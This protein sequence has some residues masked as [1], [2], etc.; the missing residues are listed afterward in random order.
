MLRL[1]L[2]GYGFSSYIRGQLVLQREREKN[3]KGNREK[4]IQIEW[5]TSYY[6]FFITI[7][8]FIQLP[9]ATR[10]CYNKANPNFLTNW[11]VT[12]S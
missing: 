11:P 10:G 6:S 3:K 8:S 2:D 5:Q 12:L 1:E 4:E 9:H 7:F